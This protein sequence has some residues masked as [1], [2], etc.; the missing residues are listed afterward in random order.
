[1]IFRT[2]RLKGAYLVELNKLADERGYFAR[3]WC[4]REFAEHNLDTSL[5][6]CNV[7]F[8]KHRGTLRGMHYQ[9]PPFAETKLVRCTR[10]AIY[11]VIVDVRPDSS[12]FLEWIGAELS[13]DNGQMMYVPHGFAH[14]FL[15]LVDNS[16]VFYQMS[17]YY[18]PESARGVRWDD[19]LFALQWPS[20]ITTLSAKD[21][22][23]ADATREQ[24]GPFAGLAA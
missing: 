14:G 4:Q 23:W 22:Q 8:N 15:T 13:E 7:S 20:A 5:V 11:D 16:E 3:S 17:E 2:T 19:P 21:Q 18:A 6:Q 9:L 24:F 12:T 10:G 1:M